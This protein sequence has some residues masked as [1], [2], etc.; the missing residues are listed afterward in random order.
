MINIWN[1]KTV[2]RNKNRKVM[3]LKETKSSL[4]IFQLSN[5]FVLWKENKYNG[6]KESNK[7]KFINSNLFSIIY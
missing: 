4:G 3:L 7:I 2:V 5:V 1:S 6:D